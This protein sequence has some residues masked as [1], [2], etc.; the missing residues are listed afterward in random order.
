MTLLKM[1]SG[2]FEF[3][4]RTEE[5]NTPESCKWLLE[6][7]PLTVQM[8]QGAWSGSAVFT[9]LNYIA[10]DVP[11]ENAT[12]YPSPGHILLYPGDEKGNSGEIY[13][14]YGGNR[15]ACPRGQLAGN[16]FLTIEEGAEQLAEFG[17]KV[18]WEG[19]QDLVFELLD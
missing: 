19:A 2:N 16:H 14:P 11:F 7:L 8:I 3:I 10:I 13:M 12:S 17:R 9:D 1:T 18:R 6:Q 5:G 4:V 15:F